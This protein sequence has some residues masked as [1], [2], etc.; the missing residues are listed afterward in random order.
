M[1]AQMTPGDGHFTFASLE[2]PKDSATN[3]KLTH[4]LLRLA[5]R[6]QNHFDLPLPIDLDAAAV[7]TRVS[8]AKPTSGIPMPDMDES[9]LLQI[10][11]EGVRL[12]AEEVWGAL[13]ALQTL[14]QLMRP[15]GDGGWV[16]PFATI[17]DRPRFPWRG[18]LLDTSRHFMGVEDVKRLLDGM[19]MAKLNVLHFHLA[20]DQGFRLECDTFPKLHEIG[21]EGAYYTKDEMSALIDA[22]AARGIRVVPEFCLP[23][24][25]VSW[26]VAYPELSAS[27]EPPTQV[28]ELR[29][30]FSVPIDPS[31]EGTYDFIDRFVAEM[32]Q[33][34][35]DPYF[36]TG[37]D[38]VNP[39]PWKNNK[40][41][42][43]F[44]QE[45]GFARARDLQA[46]FTGRYAGLVARHGKVAIGWE[47]ILHSD[48]DEN[49]LLHLWK[50]GIYPPEL[51]RHPILVSWNYY[52]DLQQPA[53][54]LYASDPHDFKVTNGNEAAGLNV[55]G[56][57]MCN[58]AE[59]IHGGN[60]DLRTWPR[61]LAVAER[62]WSAR[63]YCDGEGKATLYPR[64][65]SASR[66]LAS[67]G[68][69]HEDHVAKAMIELYGDDGAGSFAD[70]SCLIE[71][72]AYP[73]LRRRRL[74]LERALPRLFPAP[75]VERYSDVRRFVDHLA[76]E[77]EVGRQFTI[78]VELYSE[79]KTKD[80]ASALR[81]QLM[82]WQNLAERAYATSRQNAAMR[83]D[84]VPKVAKGLDRIARIG[85]AALEAL[86]KG[87]PLSPLR[88]K[89]LR[90]RLRPYAYD[91]FFIDKYLISRILK[92]LRKP[93]AL[94]KHNVAIFPG[95]SHLLS[96]ACKEEA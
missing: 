93:D 51:S 79:E 4:G 61:G 45:K 11:A 66:M 23:G 54:W 31:R 1:P 64:M 86:E 72:A 17:G 41:I 71:P 65:T 77:S 13:R 38:E 69:R 22:A 67:A 47:E 18:V 46:Y 62:F 96:K 30:I 95:V 63:S 34:F 26:Q 44:M 27:E 73:F 75:V 91:V 2:L 87:K 6:L 85:L 14:L 10:D 39:G 68:L 43:R 48:V 5:E 24:H 78:D 89:W 20:N 49:V 88:A 37:G 52:L 40:R 76:A 15:N 80:R 12:E 81:N 50:D 32:V 57:E 55:L 82:Q 60:L 19:E 28:G 84:G 3:S 53:S 42:A 21:S 29:D 36:H 16:L 59:T 56:A 25:S 70:F 83:K 9:Y 8:I 92:D 74:V 94:N 58:W 90:W 7:N 33:V 35:P